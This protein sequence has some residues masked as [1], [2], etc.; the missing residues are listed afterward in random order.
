MS[1]TMVSDSIVILLYVPAAFIYNV[2]CFEWRSNLRTILC[3][4]QRYY[5]GDED[6]MAA[7]VRLMKS[8]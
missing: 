4:E 6:G 1:Q 8:F 5:S 2:T 7:P 3:V